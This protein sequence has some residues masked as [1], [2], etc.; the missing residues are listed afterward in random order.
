MIIENND[1]KD[2]INIFE[3]T[4]FSELS[5]D[6]A[7]ELLEHLRDQFSERYM[8]LVGEWQN[9]HRAKSTRDGR[10]VSKQ[11]VIDYLSE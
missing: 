8:Y 9:G 10:F 11:E 4:N 5:H 7:I 1:K 2:F 6:G 3:S